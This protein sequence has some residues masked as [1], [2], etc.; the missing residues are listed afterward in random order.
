VEETLKGNP[1]M[2]DITIY[3]FN[4]STDPVI[5]VGERVVFFIA[6]DSREAFNRKCSVVRGYAGTARIQD[7]V[8]PLYIRGEA[9]EQRLE[10]FISESSGLCSSGESLA[11]N[12]PISHKP[13]ASV[14]PKR[15]Q[16]T[17]FADIN[18]L[19][20]LYDAYC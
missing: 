2:L 6:P 10:S 3:Q 16:A 20:Q 11:G 13:C 9:K 18:C 15:G 17:L 8:E 4:K 12:I 7:W 14:A 19:G 1:N 5:H